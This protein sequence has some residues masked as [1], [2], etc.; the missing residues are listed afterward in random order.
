MP[1]KKKMRHIEEQHDEQNWQ[2]LKDGK[3]EAL[4]VLFHQYYPV[5]FR[6]GQKSTQ[7]NIELTKEIIQDLFF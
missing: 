6:Y 2:A 3:P 5:L 4:S 7:H 1:N